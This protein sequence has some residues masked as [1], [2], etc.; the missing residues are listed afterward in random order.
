MKKPVDPA[1]GQADSNMHAA[2]NRIM[3]LPIFP[4]KHVVLFPGMVLPLH[5]F[6]LRY[7]EMINRCIDEH[8]PFGVVLIREGQEVGAPAKPHT[9]GTAARIARVER[10][11]DGR[12]NITTVGTQRFRILELHTHHSYLTATVRHFPV[13]N[14]A[15]QLAADL[16][17]RVRPQVLEYVAL[18]SK[19]AN[20]NLTLDRLP[21]DPLTL[22]MLV[23]ISLQ[24]GDLDKQ[25]L[26]EAAGVP[27]MLALEGRLLAREMLLLQYMI[28]TREDVHTLNSGPS[29]YVFPN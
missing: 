7:R 27:E 13:V 2:R 12:M 29:G 26:L 1:A 4:L 3:E 9:V 24:V 23:A 11:D 14:G 19:A 8:L 18:L 6:E 25:H 16:S 22:A 21:E 28:D 5:I 10:L 20:V 15:T 17:Q